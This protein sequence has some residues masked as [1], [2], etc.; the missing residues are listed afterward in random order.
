M[1]S[2]DMQTYDQLQLTQKGG[3]FKVVPVPKPKLGPKQ[4]LIRQRVIALN[5]VDV[6][7][8]DVGVLIDHW[9]HVLGIEGAGVIEAVGPEVHGLQPG[10]EV[11]AWEAGH[12]EGA[13]WGG[14]YQAYVAV[15]E[16]CVARRPQRITLE[17]AASLP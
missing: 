12:A 4:V 9:P 1:P 17:E 6:K 15:P 7:Q 2:L 16:H 14:A 8:R 5:L 13:F 11:L 3:P 10:D